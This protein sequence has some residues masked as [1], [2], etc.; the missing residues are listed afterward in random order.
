MDTF[1]EAFEVQNKKIKMMET[2]LLVLT[3]AAWCK[4]TKVGLERTQNSDRVL[5]VVVVHFWL[6]E[7]STDKFYNHKV[8]NKRA[9]LSWFLTVMKWMKWSESS[10]KHCNVLENCKSVKTIKKA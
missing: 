7:N 8:E 3:M 6:Q 1:V 9:A 4:E 2:S 10:S 5:L